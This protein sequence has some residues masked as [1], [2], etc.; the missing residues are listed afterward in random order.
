MYQPAQSDDI[1]LKMGTPKYLHV[2]TWNFKSMHN[3]F[4]T[5]LLHDILP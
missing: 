5:S 1:F 4:P 2:R 3:I